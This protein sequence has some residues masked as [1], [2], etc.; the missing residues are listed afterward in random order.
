MIIIDIE[1]TG[2]DELKH[3]IIEIAAIQFDNPGNF[4]HSLC[5]VDDEDEI[6]E[7]AL[8]INGQKINDVRDTNR[9]NQKQIL[10]ELFDFAFR[11]NDFY[12]AGENIGTF[13]LRFLLYKSKKYNLKY[14]FQY[15]SFDL[16]TAAFLTIEKFNKKSIII[17]GKNELN[18]GKILE[19]VGLKDTRKYHN[20][21][22]DVKLEAEAISR[23]Q[24]GKNLFPEYS[25]FPVPIHLVK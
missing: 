21:L 2:L 22:E 19:F 9:K 10:E 15:R 13:D 20:A 4:Y 18:L 12:A 3:G 5:K 1:T 11:I 14:P 7:K 6:D 25:I 24:Y 17:K 23:L 16:N 8:E